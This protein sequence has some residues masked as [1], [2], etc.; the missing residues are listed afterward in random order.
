MAASSILPS[1]DMVATVLSPVPVSV[2]T[3][4]R[5]TYSSTGPSQ[6]D[7]AQQKFVLC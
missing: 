3:K 5:D 2:L 6:R 1:G 4:D 7:L